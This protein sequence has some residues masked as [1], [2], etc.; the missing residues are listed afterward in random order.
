M[1]KGNEMVKVTLNT[2]VTFLSCGACLLGFNRV[3]AEAFAVSREGCIEKGAFHPSYLSEADCIN[4]QLE[5]E[6]VI[7]ETISLQRKMQVPY[8]DGGVH[9]PLYYVSWFRSADGS[10]G[11]LV[12]TFIEISTY[13]EKQ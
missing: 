8:D 5:D 2:A 9:D 1:D 10:L 6:H 7:A 3:Y 4:Y 11:G 13:K 12:G